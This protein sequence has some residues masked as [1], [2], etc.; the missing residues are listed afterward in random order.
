MTR[1]HSNARRA[2]LALIGLAA[3]PATPVPAQ[4]AIRIEG[5][6]PQ[7]LPLDTIGDLDISQPAQTDE[8]P[9]VDVAVLNLGAI[10]VPSGRLAGVDALVLEGAPYQ[11]PIGPGRYPLQIVLARLSSGEERVAFVQL[12]LADRNAESWSN[13]IIEGD[14]EL[15]DDEIS[16]FEVESS[17]AALFDAAALALWRR[18]LAERPELLV[19][20]QRVLRENRRPNWTWARVQVGSGSGVLFTAG[21]GEGEYGAYWGHA[22]DGQIVSLVIDLDLLDW[23]GLPEDP[24]VTI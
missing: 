17:V 11:P 18:T 8:D 21:R 12:K 14:D 10:D 6:V 2:L 1:P 20:L 24:P 15:Q 4:P 23:A 7:R 3:L 9:V 19:D 22:A 16:V 13:A 5:G